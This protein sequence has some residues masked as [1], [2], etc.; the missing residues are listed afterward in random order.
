MGSYVWDDGDH[1]LKFTW[2]RCEDR[3]W[4][5][6]LWVDDRN[7]WSFATKRE[8]ILDVGKEAGDGF[9]AGQ[10][11]DPAILFQRAFDDPQRGLHVIC[12]LAKGGRPWGRDSD[13][14]L[15]MADFVI[16]G[17]RIY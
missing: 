6:S 13:A 12:N 8:G 16:K 15:K 1:L 14:N 5:L 7:V 9:G 4:V 3:A 2:K 17:V 10:K 11:G